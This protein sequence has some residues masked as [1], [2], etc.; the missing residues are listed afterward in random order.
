MSSSKYWTPVTI[1]L[2]VAIAISGTAA[3]SR[4]RSYQPLE[5]ALASSP[6]ATRGNLHRWRGQ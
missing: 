2:I 5:I 3:W 4:Y 6:P 1:F